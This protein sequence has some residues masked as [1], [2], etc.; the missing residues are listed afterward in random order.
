MLDTGKNKAVMALRRKV[1]RG[2]SG[3]ANPVGI[4]G[5]RVGRC[6]APAATGGILLESQQ[7]RVVNTGVTGSMKPQRGAAY[8]DGKLAKQY[9]QRAV[10]YANTV[11]VRKAR[12]MSRMSSLPVHPNTVPKHGYPASKEI[13]NPNVQFTM[14]KALDAWWGRKQK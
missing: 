13:R 7:G 8:V 5:R 6:K 12:Q 11:D 14:R 3:M 4:M 9:C 10:K 2:T 1:M